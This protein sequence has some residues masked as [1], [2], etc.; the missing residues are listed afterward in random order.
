MS[1]RIAVLNR[2]HRHDPHDP[3]VRD[4]VRQRAADACEYCL[5][6]TNGKFEIEH[7]VPKQRWNDYVNGKYPGLRRAERLALPT[8]DHI[9]NFAWS[10]FFCNNAKGGRRHLR[11]ATRVFDPRFDHWPK[12]FAFSRTSGPLVIVGLTAIGRETVRIMRFHAGGEEGALVQ[13]AWT[14]Q[15]GLYPPPWLREAYSL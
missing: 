8:Y 1:Y 10:C 7:I 14:I 2:L 15:L 6:P 13:R 9:S 3:T 11:T 5:M 4:V 12:H